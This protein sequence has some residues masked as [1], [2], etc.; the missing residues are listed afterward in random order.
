MSQTQ[1]IDGQVVPVLYNGIMKYEAIKERTVVTNYIATVKYNGKLEKEVV[2]TVTLTVEYTEVPTQK[3]E[4]KQETKSNS[5]INVFIYNF[6]NNT[7]KLVRKTKVKASEKLI[8]ITPQNNE[9]SRKYKIVLKNDLYTKWYGQN[10]TVKYFDKQFIC[11]V[12]ENEIEIV[13]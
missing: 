8:D 2:D 5:I 12:K 9:I 10:I 1:I 11:N 3:I 7:W 4:E 6:Q 13:V